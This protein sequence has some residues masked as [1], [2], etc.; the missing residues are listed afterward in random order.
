QRKD[1]SVTHCDYIWRHRWDSDC[2][3]GI[4]LQRRTPHINYLIIVTQVV[5]SAFRNKG[6]AC[7]RG[8]CILRWR[9]A[10]K[11]HQSCGNPSTKTKVKPVCAL[12]CVKKYSIVSP[13]TWLTLL[14]IFLLGAQRMLLFVTLIG[15]LCR[16]IK[17]LVIQV[18]TRETAQFQQ[19]FAPQRYPVPR[20]RPRCPACQ[21]QGEN[22]CQ[23]CCRCGSS[24]HFQAGCRGNSGIPTKAR[25]YPLNDGWLP[26]GDKE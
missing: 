20:P 26:L 17:V 6:D 4:L 15:D 13:I 22:V 3:A 12:Q 19:R 9:K 2:E 10:I 5:E 25:D 21:Q 14:H 11:E 16:S 18:L 7:P 8:L 1:V 24:E 23:H